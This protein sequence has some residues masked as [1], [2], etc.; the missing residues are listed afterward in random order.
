MIEMIKPQKFNAFTISPVA[1][2]LLAKEGEIKS[3][4]LILSGKL[5]HL[6]EEK[7]MERLRESYV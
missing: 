1:A 6:Q 5:N 3:V 7:I 2:Y 4:R